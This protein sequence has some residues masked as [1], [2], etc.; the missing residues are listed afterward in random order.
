MLAQLVADVATKRTPSTRTAR[1]SPKSVDVASNYLL[2]GGLGGRPGGHR[3]SGGK[4]PTTTKSCESWNH[5]CVLLGNGRTTGGRRTLCVRSLHPLSS[6]RPLRWC[7]DWKLPSGRANGKRLGDVVEGRTLASPKGQWKASL[8][9]LRT[10]SFFK[11]FSSSE[12]QSLSGR[13]PAGD[14]KLSPE[15]IKLRPALISSDRT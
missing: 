6:A 4:S 12:D 13:F 2:W 7:W 9:M 11:L 15:L 14:L 3:I 8:V 1:S 5:R 10:S